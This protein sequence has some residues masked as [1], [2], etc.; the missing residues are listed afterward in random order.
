MR[1]Q[2][3]VAVCCCCVLLLCAVVV[4]CYCVLKAGLHAQ[5]SLGWQNS[6]NHSFN[7]THSVTFYLLDDDWPAS[8]SL[9]IIQLCTVYSAK[10]SCGYFL[11]YLEVILQNDKLLLAQQGQLTM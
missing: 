8:R 7:N 6:C 11:C 3:A 9:A 4:Y 10:A 5:M 2:G 1:L